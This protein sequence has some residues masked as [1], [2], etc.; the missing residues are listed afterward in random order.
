V[1][2]GWI[3]I[4]RAWMHLPNSRSR[5]L[6]G[7]VVIACVAALAPVTAL[8]ATASPTGHAGAATAAS[9]PKC[10]TSGLVIWLDTYGNGYAGGVGYNLEFTNLSGHKCTLSGYPGVS[11]VNLGGHRLGSPA[12]HNGP[13][14]GVVNLANGATTTAL[15][16]IGDVG[17]FT[18]STCHYVEAA[19]LMV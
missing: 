11:A 15:L 13:K 8:A 7:A 19:G 1:K 16:E 17:H 6:I 12:R 14:L 10:M 5:R 2:A 4:G 3:A 9:T 18:P